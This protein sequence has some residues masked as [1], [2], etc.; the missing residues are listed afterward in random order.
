MNKTK[1]PSLSDM[2]HFINKTEP[3]KATEKKVTARTNSSVKKGG[4]VGRPK[5]NKY[6]TEAP[7][8][9]KIPKD[10]HKELK[11]AS[12]K[13]GRPMVEIIVDAV[14]QHLNI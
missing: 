2:N 8:N 5:M 7:L 1:K 9:V 4:K 11:L 10:I 12:V 6:A 13:K 3:R 14:K